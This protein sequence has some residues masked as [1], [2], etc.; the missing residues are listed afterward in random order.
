MHILQH[1]A[2][3]AQATVI[4]DSSLAPRT[5]TRTAPSATLCVQPP[6]NK[7]PSMPVLAIRPG[8]RTRLKSRRRSASCPTLSAQVWSI[9]QAH[10]PSA[11]C[12]RLRTWTSLTPGRLPALMVRSIS[13]VSASTCRSRARV[14]TPGPRSGP[15][16]HLT[17]QPSRQRGD[18]T[19]LHPQTRERARHPPQGCTTRG[20]TTLH[21]P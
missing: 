17:E 8:P 14:S 21:H 12:L 10:S 19:S 7:P 2:W 11:S 16:T 6:A 1:S 18:E 9:T 3:P 20:P 13:S 15:G 4:A 5:L